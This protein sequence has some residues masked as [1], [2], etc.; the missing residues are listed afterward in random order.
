[1]NDQNKYI[2]LHKGRIPLSGIMV[3]CAINTCV[4]ARQG[5]SLVSVLNKICDKVAAPAESDPIYTAWYNSF[6][7][8][9][10]GKVLS[11]DGSTFTWITPPWGEVN[12]AS[13]VGGGEGVFQSK[14]GLDLRFKSLIEGT[15]IDIT[16]DALE[17]TIENTAPDQIVTLT[18]GANVTITGTY[19]NFTIASTGG[20][21]GG[22]IS[23][24]T[25]GTANNTLDVVGFVQTW[26]WS[27]LGD[28]GLILAT[29]SANISTVNANLLRLAASGTKTTLNGTVHGLEIDVTVVPDGGIT[30]LNRGID[31]L[32]ANGTN[33]R[34]AEFRA[35]GGIPSIDNIALV[36]EATGGTN[37]YALIV[38]NGDGFSG[39][40]ITS[41]TTTVHINGANSLRYTD[42]NET[43]GYVL[44]SDANGVASWAPLAVT[45]YTDEMSQDAIGGM[46]DSTLTYVDGT[47]LLQVTPNTTVQKIEVT[48]NSGAIVGTRKQL[49]FIEGANVTLTIADDAGNDQIDITVA[50]SG[51]ASG[52]ATVQEEGVSLTQRSVINFIGGGITAVDDAGNT[53]TNVSLDSTLNSLAAYNTN[54]LLTQTAADTFTGRTITNGTGISVANGDGVAGNPVITNTA[55]DQTVV[56]NNGTGISVTGTY[57][58]FTITST[59]VDTD[60]HFGNTDLTATGDRVHTFGAF[61]SDITYNSLTG[62]S[63]FRVSSTS[64]AAASNLQRLM[65]VALSGANAT[66]SQTTV[67]GYFSNT[68]TGTTPTN[69]GVYATASGGTSSDRAGVFEGAAGNASFVLRGTTGARN[70]D[71]GLGAADVVLFQNSHT[72]A[73]AGFDFQ[74]RTAVK[75]FQITTT[76]LRTPNVPNAT[77]DTD[78]FLVWDTADLNK[79]KYRTGTELASDLGVGGIV[80]TGVQYEMAFYPANGTTVDGNSGI[81]TNANNRL[82]V[83][84]SEERALQINAGGTGLGGTYYPIADFSASGMTASQVMQYLVG[85]NDALNNK[86]SIDFVYA[87]DGSTNNYM[88]LGFYANNDKMKIYASGNV[89]IGVAGIPGERLVVNGTFRAT[90]SMIGETSLTLG[91][92]GGTAGS[93]IVNGNTSGTITIQPQAAAGTYNL[94]L[95]TTAGSSGQLLTSGGGVGVPM[96]WT[97]GR[98]AQS[99]TTYTV[100]TSDERKIIGLSNTAARTITLC[101]ANAVDAGVIIWFKDEAGTASTGNVTINR[102]GADTIDGATS[103]VLNVNYSVIGLYSDGVSAWF[104]I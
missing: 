1:M 3:D 8:A 15:G 60:T 79:I 89:G 104:T 68:H 32:V 64:T 7:L 74:T 45:Q 2:I 43:L 102:V 57:P 13:N 18:E 69:Y 11:S 86:Y 101:A 37:N 26:N 27:A 99:G 36:L 12:T 93:L 73:Q 40:G 67:A 59:V 20:G 92:T 44:T 22:A 54:G 55:P 83:T 25:D 100:Q 72:S 48:K 84:A 76:D 96:R 49:N 56:L 80:N 41:P 65:E 4:P 51:G 17:I 33:N 9:Q 62:E 81:V 42:T 98:N 10:N 85:R 29:N 82:M 23:D 90:S 16:S 6:A 28:D 46:I 78:R 39:F 38:D 95:P 88:G 71:I 19:P 53:R 14:L 30:L 21:G 61:Q 5:E 91:T 24:L 97:G 66:A 50:S 77:V 87:G 103:F 58:T 34:A 94:N 70:I 75:I 52:Y 35:L 47:P 31:V 63:G